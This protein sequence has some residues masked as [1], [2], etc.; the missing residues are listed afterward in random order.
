MG[1]QEVPYEHEEE[2]LYCKGDRAL[3]QALITELLK[4]TSRDHLVQDPC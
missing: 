3:E 4:G 2:L 1:T